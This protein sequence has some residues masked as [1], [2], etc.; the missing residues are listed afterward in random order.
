MKV[1]DFAK[2]YDFNI[3][4]YLKGFG[5]DRQ[6]T[7]TE[8]YRF[9][10]SCKFDADFADAEKTVARIETESGKIILVIK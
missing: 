3:P 2:K 1:R 4:L 9:N 10:K 6:L 8:C 5:V 7:P